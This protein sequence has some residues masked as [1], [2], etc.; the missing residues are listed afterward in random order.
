MLHSTAT[1]EKASVLGFFLRDPPLPEPLASLLSITFMVSVGA[2]S[3]LKAVTG[4]TRRPEHS[5]QHNGR[6]VFKGLRV[7]ESMISDC[8]KQTRSI[9]WVGGVYHP[10]LVDVTQFI[11]PIKDNKS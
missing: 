9:S 2:R 3:Q 8:F 5:T 4:R 6:I 11:Y 10:A 1:Q 7:D